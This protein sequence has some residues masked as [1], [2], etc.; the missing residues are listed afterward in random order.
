MR[1]TLCTLALC[2][3]ALAVPACDATNGGDTFPGT[4]TSASGT[5]LTT[6]AKDLV[7]PQ[8]SR[9]VS[10]PSAILPA[11]LRHQ[12]CTDFK[13]KLDKIRQD[14][15]QAAAD[16]AV[17]DTIAGYPSSPDWAVFTDE[18]RQAVIDG[19]HDAAAG[20]CPAG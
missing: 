20:D 14:S 17:D 11:K 6:T 15:G 3:L 9:S 16:R 1:R 10:V 5:A 4:S 19:T 8:N 18:Q 12:T 7:P 13:P 2:S